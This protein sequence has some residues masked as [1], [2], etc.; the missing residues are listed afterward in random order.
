[1]KLLFFDIDGTL[2]SEKTG[3]IPKSAKRA[4]KKAQ[5]A[6]HLVF[7]NTGRP[8][9]TIEDK[10]LNL[11]L[12]GMSAVADPILSFMARFYIAVPYLM[13]YVWKLWNN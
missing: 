4:I 3:L 2:M 1:M 6:G 13:N 8:R 7:I 12:D 9:S 10:I 5:E 11:G